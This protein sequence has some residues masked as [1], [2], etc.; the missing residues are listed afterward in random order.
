[1]NQ[2]H[3]WTHIITPYISDN[4]NEQF[5][6]FKRV[7]KTHIIMCS[8]IKVTCSFTMI[9]LSCNYL[10]VCNW[11][12]YLQPEWQTICRIDDPIFTVHCKKCHSDKCICHQVLRDDVPC[13]LQPSMG[14]ATHVEY[15]N[16]WNSPLQR[17]LSL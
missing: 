6:S 11:F 14:S 3:T 10:H 16:N 13:A 7:N 9:I 4:H 8:G 15:S 17:S 1:V 12:T 5:L 2:L